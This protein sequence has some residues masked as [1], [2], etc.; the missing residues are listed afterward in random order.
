M[1]RCDCL[2]LRA[3][4]ARGL[5]HGDDGDVDDEALLEQFGILPNRQRSTNSDNVPVA[6]RKCRCWCPPH[7]LRA[8]YTELCV[9]RAASFSMESAVRVEGDID[10]DRDSF[11]E[12]DDTTER[13]AEEK[14]LTFLSSVRLRRN[15]AD[16]DG[17]TCSSSLSI[18]DLLARLSVDSRLSIRRSLPR[19]LA[20]TLCGAFGKDEAD[21]L[22]HV[23][24]ILFYFF[25]LYQ[26]EH[27][28]CHFPHRHATRLVRASFARKAA[29]SMSLIQ[30]PRRRRRHRLRR[31]RRRLRL[32]LHR[33]RLRQH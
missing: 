4:V 9:E 22:L 14:Q 33:Q 5:R 2:G 16:G 8:V 3:C 20:E 32:R 25:T 27:T 30:T 23:C 19:W 1:C 6:E 7:V 13:F 12:W 21:R 28:N 29:L 18:S 10:P 24:C 26:Q 17:A 31:R 15:D 11:A